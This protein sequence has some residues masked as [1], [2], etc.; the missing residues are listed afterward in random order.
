[1]TIFRELLAHPGV[2]EDVV[3]RSQFGIMAFH[4]GLEGGTTE[5]AVEAAATGG[6]SLYTVT[7]P[8]DLV[9]HVPSH[10][11]VGSASVRLT[12]FL[13]HVD[14]VITV[15]GYG[16]PDR[17]R[18]LLLG[19][20]NRDLAELL[21]AVLRQHLPDYDVID[22]LDAM[23]KEMRGLHAD[24][25]VNQAR[26]GGVQLELP[27]SIRGSSPSPRERGRPC[28]PDP[29][30]AAALAAFARAQSTSNVPPARQ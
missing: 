24:N 1:M 8:S 11:V 9:W 3:L 26:C 22:E 14:A 13:G 12:E 2:E 10:R 16:R 30:L 7:Q 17:P 6:A 19:G 20:Q 4:G 23:P 5:I 15:H 21:A 25:P 29:R 27:P 18:Q 28:S